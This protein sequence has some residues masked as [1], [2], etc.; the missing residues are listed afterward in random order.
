MSNLKFR[1][2]TGK[3]LFYQEDQYLASF[4]RRAVSA[5]CRDSG[6]TM[7]AET[8]ESYLPNGG[9]IEEYLTQYT[10]FQDE[11]GTDIYDKDIVRFTNPS[12]GKKWKRSHG[13]ID[14]NDMVVSWNTVRGCWGLFWQNKAGEL[15]WQ[16]LAKALD[17]HHLVVGNVYQNKDL[18][19]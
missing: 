13:D 8:H 7:G 19:K 17:Q 2:W 4:I 1:A 6:D 16:S 12:P 11:K 3:E 14:Y 15:M 9:N 5:I 18:I 10:T